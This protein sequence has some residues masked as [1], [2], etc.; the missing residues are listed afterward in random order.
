MEPILISLLLS[1]SIPI[2]HLL[3]INL[4]R[5]E[6]WHIRLMFLSFIS[7]MAL[8]LIV[9]YILYG[10]ENNFYIHLLV[11]ISSTTFVNLFYLETFSMVARGF[12]MRIITDIYLNSHL[13]LDGISR[14]YAQ[15]KGIDWLLRK[16]L[17]GIKDLDLITHEG[18]NIKLSSK[19]AWLIVL[20]SKKFKKILNLGK[21]G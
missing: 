15:G 17:E 20:F 7:Y 14:E 13:D 3:L 21:G 19:K 16:R 11:S 9:K 5:R 8:D 2:I 1:L 6:G 4:I 18:Q 10:Q 12:S